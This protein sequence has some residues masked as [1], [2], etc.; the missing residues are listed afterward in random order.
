MVRFSASEIDFA[1]TAEVDAVPSATAWTMPE[2][3]RIAAG[4]AAARFP[5]QIQGSLARIEIRTVGDTEWHG[6]PPAWNEG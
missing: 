2:L 6:R 4:I 1:V 5:R 3:D